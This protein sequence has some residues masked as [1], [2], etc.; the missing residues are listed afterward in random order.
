MCGRQVMY[1]VFLWGTY[2]KDSNTD[3]LTY[4]GHLTHTS[5]ANYVA[6]GNCGPQCFNR[7]QKQIISNNPSGDRFDIS[8]LFLCIKVAC[9]NMAGMSDPAWHTVGSQLE[10]CLYQIKQQRNTVMHEELEMSEVEFQSKTRWLR[11]L[12][13]D[14]LN[15]AQQRY[16]HVSTTELAE[17]TQNVCEELDLINSEPV[18]VDDLLMQCGPALQVDLIREVTSHLKETFKEDA[19][20]DPLSFLSGNTLRLQIQKIFTKIRI[21]KGKQQGLQTEVKFKDLLSLVQGKSSRPQIM[22]IEG[23]AGSGKSTLL[24]LVTAEWVDGGVGTLQNLNN[25]QLLLRVQCR[26]S[27]LTT[28]KDLLEDLMLPA[29][30]EYRSLFTRL[31]KLCRILVIIDGLDEC[32]DQSR[33]LVSDIVNQLQR[34]PDCT[35]L[36]TTR[37]EALQD[38]VHTVPKRYDVSI[39]QL[40]GIPMELR[41]EFVMRYFKEIQ[42]VAEL[43]GIPIGNSTTGKEL[44]KIMES[45]KRKEHFRLPLNLVMLV[46]L[47]IFKSNIVN[48]TT[49]QTELYHHTHQ[50]CQEKLDERLA[51]NTQTKAMN[52]RL[53]QKKLKTWLSEMYRTVLVALSKNQL[54][55]SEHDVGH[56]RHMC[57]KLDIPEDEVMSAFLN[58]KST[59]TPVD[60]MEHYSAP[61]KGLQEYYGAL[62]VMKTLQGDPASGG[63]M[64]ALENAIGVGQVHL[65]MFQNLLQQVA[66][67]LHLHLDPVPDTL[68][69]EVA[70]LLHAAGVTRRDQWLDILE[71]SKASPAI[72][73]AI[74]RHFPVPPPALG[75][76]DDDDDDEENID[77]EDGRARSYSHLLPHLP[78]TRIKIDLNGDSECL[79]TPMLHDLHRHTCKMLQ[80][81]HHFHHPQTPRAASDHIIQQVLARGGI[82]VFVGQLSANVGCQLPTT[83]THLRLAITTDL[84]AAIIPH[85]HNLPHLH[86][87]GLHVGAEVTP[88]AVTSL[89]DLRDGDGGSSVFLRLSGV[90]SGQEERA[91]DLTSRLQPPPGFWDI[92]FPRATLKEEGW[93]KVVEGLAVRGVRVEGVRV[94]TDSLTA[95]Q[96]RH[97]NILAKTRLGARSGVTRFDFKRRGWH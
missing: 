67:L 83:L 63:I 6:A 28:F 27:H 2:G 51:N 32:N 91:C 73:S 10:N 72:L 95:A 77:I 48:E 41:V 35:F 97:I 74:I 12:L 56:L 13:I 94:P 9:E 3:L 65:S 25:Y 40:V 62:Y 84:Q 93:Q 37:P 96:W 75:D 44:V 71:G 23:L 52:K 68:A 76:D 64:T 16:A 53:R 57:T 42:R 61:H 70:D 18:G 31:V 5:T 92:W 14:T 86:D 38:F 60:V 45:E 15:S 24:T 85:L 1:T 89:P 79:L 59:W 80:L 21:V 46:W 87:L 47:F 17:V 30:L 43:Q 81:W 39:V 78:P 20:M 49:T 55:L 36:C 34:V 90:T 11:Q 19:F 54:I 50:L 4:L 33:H 26:D 88:G 7:Y 66:C 82:K 69:E 8:L 58:M 29:S 22:I